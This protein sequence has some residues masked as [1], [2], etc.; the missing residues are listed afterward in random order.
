MAMDLSIRIPVHLLKME[1]GKKVKCE[2]DPDLMFKKGKYLNPD[3]F[4]PCLA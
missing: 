3:F 2:N 1:G 4:Y